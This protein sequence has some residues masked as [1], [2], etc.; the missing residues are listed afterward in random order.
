MLTT[1]FLLAALVSTPLVACMDDADLPADPAATEG[2][3]TGDHVGTTGTTAD[4]TTGAN[5]EIGFAAATPLQRQRAVEAALGLAAA[6]AIALADSF[7]K[8]SLFNCPSIEVV[9]DGVV[10]HGG[11][12]RLNQVFVGGSASIRNGVYTF[13]DFGVL[14]RSVSA[15]RQSHV[16]GKLRRSVTTTGEASLIASNLTVSRNVFEGEL[17]KVVSNGSW[18]NDGLGHVIADSLPIIKPV[19]SVLGVGDYTVAATFALTGDTGTVTLA[20]ESELTATRAGTC[21]NI[22]VDTANFGTACD[23]PAFTVLAS[24]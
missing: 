8:P 9:E 12:S 2:G 21:W 5:V 7:A 23:V 20:G 15:T 14:D 1:R 6:F 10:L 16:D 13:T 19:I 4:P 18:L 17:V 3:L 22:H 11:C 24:H